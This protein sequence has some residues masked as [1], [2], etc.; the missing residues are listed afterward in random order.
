MGGPL[1]RL[2]VDVDCERNAAGVGEKGSV[3]SREERDVR[4]RA[5]GTEI[6]VVLLA[7]LFLD[8]SRVS[9][10]LF[11]VCLFKVVPMTVLVHLLPEATQDM[12]KEKDILLISARHDSLVREFF[13]RIQGDLDIQ[14][15]NF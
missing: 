11:F 5:R 12:T 3:L 1:N 14:M 8:P 9:F 6:G 15:C 4:G 10:F 13:F 2:T 7:H